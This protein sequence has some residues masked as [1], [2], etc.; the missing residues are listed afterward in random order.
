[1]DKTD[2]AQ[3]WIL[4]VGVR[5]YQAALIVTDSAKL[6]SNYLEVIIFTI[7]LRIIVHH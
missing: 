6:L 5:M 1:M 3:E 4:M 2:M 7:L